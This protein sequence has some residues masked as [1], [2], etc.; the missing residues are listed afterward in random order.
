[1]S[2]T[3]SKKTSDVRYE[4]LVG[5]ISIEELLE[6][7]RIYTYDDVGIQLMHYCLRLCISKISERDGKHTFEHV[8]TGSL[9]SF[10]SSGLDKGTLVNKFNFNGKKAFMSQRPDAVFQL[11]WTD[12]SQSEQQAFVYY[13][14]DAH[15][16]NVIDDQK[17]S[18]ALKMLQDTTGCHEIN[19]DVPAITVRSNLFK[20]PK[21]L[22]AR[23]STFLADV[24]NASP[25]MRAKLIEGGE[26]ENALAF[27]YSMCVAHMWTC[28]QI[29]RVIHNDGVLASLATLPDR[30]RYD[31]HLLLGRFEHQGNTSMS[32]FG[33][34]HVVDIK[35][36]TF[37]VRRGALVQVVA[38]ERFNG[39]AEFQKNLEMMAAFHVNGV[40]KKSLIPTTGMVDILQLWEMHWKNQ[41]VCRNTGRPCT[42]TNITEVLGDFY[43]PPSMI[44]P[45]IESDTTLTQ[46]GQF[47]TAKPG[48]T[49]H[50]TIPPI[51]YG[52]GPLGFPVK[53]ANLQRLEECDPPM[54]QTNPPYCVKENS[55]KNSRNLLNLVQDIVALY[56]ANM[57]LYLYKDIT[58]HLR[59]D[60]KGQHDVD[61]LDKM[62]TLKMRSRNDATSLYGRQNT[63]SPSSLG[64][65]H[66]IG[67]RKES[68]SLEALILF[69][70]Y[71]HLPD[72]DSMLI[73]YL[74][75]FNAPNLALFLRMI[76]C[77]NL[78]ALRQ[79]ADNMSDAHISERYSKT[80]Q[81]LPLGSISELMHVMHH[82]RTD[83]NRLPQKTNM[84]V[85]M[86]AAPT[87]SATSDKSK[88]DTLMEYI[89][90][91][92][93]EGVAASSK[94]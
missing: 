7:N 86:I 20:G 50:R 8:N 17:R 66:D 4:Q 81:T 63:A 34:K 47:E 53:T 67:H 55:G 61:Y 93:R 24:R 44:D 45:I 73:A 23:D 72:L 59:Y 27:L 85:P 62:K 68:T 13:E 16:K 6:I 52:T 10:I 69:D 31:L 43:I 9:R 14:C 71:K 28:W 89:Y 64:M 57:I 94:T 51:K 38:I 92:F 35:N 41:D 1:M 37:A 84:P 33:G 54:P 19:P 60:L 58:Y 78:L 46:Q 5:E 76:R 21:T 39:L 30:R 36:Y 25:S 70:M 75:Q 32:M 29:V 48:P 83:Q 26:A 22:I 91:Q 56:H 77:S 74:K 2:A 82:T 12:Y 3:N 87:Q 18:I 80:L 79:L 11:K 65:H 49:G 42:W 15:S 40:P 88:T 90:T